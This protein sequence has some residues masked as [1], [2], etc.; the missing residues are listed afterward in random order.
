MHLIIRFANGRRAEALL[1]TMTDDTLRV[2]MRAREETIE[3]RRVSDRWEGDDGSNVAIE[4]LMPVMPA[5]AERPRTFT[6]GGQTSL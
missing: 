2:I 1:L 3:Y 5:V 4:A 6:A